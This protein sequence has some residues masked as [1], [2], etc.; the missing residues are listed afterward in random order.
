MTG[1]PV[2]TILMAAG[3][4]LILIGFAGVLVHRNILR[5][6]IGFSLIDTGVA[7]VIVASGY[8]KGGTAPIL[9]AD[10]DPASVQFVDPVTSALTVTAIVIGLAVTAVMLAYAIRLYRATGTLDID[11]F[12]ESRG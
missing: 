5:M 8:V 1:L 9:D 6:V 2:S 4:G 10:V 3:F 11:A 12:R 7:V